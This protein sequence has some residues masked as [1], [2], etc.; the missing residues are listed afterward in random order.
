VTKRGADTSERSAVAEQDDNRI[1]LGDRGQLQANRAGVLR[2]R[3]LGAI[4]DEA[5]P[6]AAA[7]WR[8]PSLAA[9]KS[10]PSNR[11]SAPSR[12][13]A[14]IFIGLAVS[15]VK[16]VQACPRRPEA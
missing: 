8:A 3:R 12:C 9:S 5:R 10:T 6:T 7:C 4:L 14:A 16:T 1:H 11:T 15:T 13:M 2:D